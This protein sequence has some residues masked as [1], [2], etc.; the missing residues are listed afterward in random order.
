MPHF[1]AHARACM[2]LKVGARGRL[3]KASCNGQLPKPPN[4][5]NKPTP[6]SFKNKL[7]LDPQPYPLSRIEVINPRP[8]TL[9]GP[10]A[11]GLRATPRPHQN[12][13][14]GFGVAETQGV[15]F[16][17]LAFWG[18][19]V[20]GFWGFEGYDVYGSELRVTGSLRA[21]EN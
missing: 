12:S 4:L 1:E 2:K 18:F 15:W 16:E 8:W 21:H 17:V 10:F 14:F 20:W 5:S 11:P 3:T 19:G 13:S 7:D 6:P 9:N